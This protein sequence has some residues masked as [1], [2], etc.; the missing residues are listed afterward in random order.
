M[1]H[2]A[3]VPP[4]LRGVF[5][6]RVGGRAARQCRL[7]RCT[8]DHVGRRAD[9]GDGLNALA[10]TLRR[11]RRGR[12]TSRAPTRRCSDAVTAAIIKNF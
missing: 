9:G 2:R 10:A 3:T 12:R 8:R 7:Q 6:E 1:R 4:D 11:V 5:L